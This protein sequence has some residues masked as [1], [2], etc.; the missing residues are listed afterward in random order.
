VGADVRLLDRDLVVARDG[1]SQHAG[2]IRIDAGAERQ[3]GLSEIEAAFAGADLIARGR[4][5]CDAPVGGVARRA[6]ETAAEDQRDRRVECRGAACCAGGRRLRHRRRCRGHRHGRIGRRGVRGFEL[7]DAC[8]ERVDTRV[9]VALQ[10]LHL[11]AQ[12]GHVI[13][14][15]R[16]CGQCDQR[17]QRQH[18]LRMP[19]RKTPSENPQTR[20]RASAACASK[21]FQ[22]EAGGARERKE[23]PWPRGASVVAT[24]AMT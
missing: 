22:K 9:V 20:R 8:F 7:F 17:D 4:E 6:G 14:G 15:R 11:G 3:L 10:C 5:A 18:G 16:Q 12:A 24:T 19:H 21:R 13:G 2:E 1:G 23:A